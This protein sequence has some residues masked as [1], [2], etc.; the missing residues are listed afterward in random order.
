MALYLHLSKHHLDEIPEILESS[1][2]NSG[3]RILGSN[4]YKIKHLFTYF[5]LYTF[6]LGVCKAELQLL[7]S[8]D[9][10][11][12]PTSFSIDE[13]R[14]SSSLDLGLQPDDDSPSFPMWSTPPAEL[15]PDGGP[16]PPPLELKSFPPILRRPP[17]R[18]PSSS[19]RNECIH[20]FISKIK[21]LIKMLPIYLVKYLKR[22]FSPLRAAVF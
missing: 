21:M 18:R 17:V 3:S 6:P 9:K 1:D 4:I 16:V 11:I 19:F 12:L 13:A 22:T 14:E 7:G 5:D 10:L 15:S 2:N 20:I 8:E